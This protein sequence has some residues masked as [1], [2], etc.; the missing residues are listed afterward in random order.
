MLVEIFVTNQCSED[1]I[2]SG[3]PIFEIKLETE[4]D[5]KK[6]YHTSRITGET[7]NFDNSKFKST[8][9]LSIDIPTTTLLLEKS[10][11]C[12]IIPDKMKCTALDQPLCSDS[13]LEIVFLGNYVNHPTAIIQRAIDL[14]YPLKDCRICSECAT[15]DYKMRYIRCRLSGRGETPY[16]MLP[17]YAYGCPYYHAN[18]NPSRISVDPILAHSDK[19]AINNCNFTAYHHNA[20][21]NHRKRM[22]SSRN[23]KDVVNRTSI[24]EK[25]D[26]FNDRI[27]SWFEQRFLLSSF[28]IACLK[29]ELL[30]RPL[31]ENTTKSFEGYVYLDCKPHFNQFKIFRDRDVFELW[32]G[33]E[34]TRPHLYI[35]IF[36]GQMPFPPLKNPD[37]LV[38]FACCTNFRPGRKS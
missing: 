25:E 23:K 7:Y 4:E 28:H 22:E 31:P 3:L 2:N 17:F 29:S 15:S 11:E 10:G 9:P 1:K 30:S 37:A 19:D 21:E 20:V 34:Q 38:I 33:E 8:S 14:G 16:N 5:A 27:F 24:N 35:K 36:T 6:L 32:N 26:D 12:R 18:P 13:I